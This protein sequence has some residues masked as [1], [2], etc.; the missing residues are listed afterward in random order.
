MR[1]QLLLFVP[2]DASA[3]LAWLLTWY[4]CLALV[5]W[6]AQQGAQH[7]LPTACST[8]AHAAQLTTA[9]L[10]HTKHPQ[11]QRFH[12]AHKA[13]HTQTYSDHHCLRRSPWWEQLLLCCQKLGPL[14]AG[15]LLLC[16]VGFWLIGR[17]ACSRKMRQSKPEAVVLAAS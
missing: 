10:L 7:Q 15:L 3:L 16:S 14:Q 4:I 11:G 5:T 6:M 12:K 1:G 17:A 2:Q 8:T 9:H 13:C